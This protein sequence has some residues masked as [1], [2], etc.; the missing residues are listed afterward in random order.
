MKH[1]ITIDARMMHFTGIGTYVRN[2]LENFGA[3]EHEFQFKVLCSARDF[4]TSLLGTRFKF[5]EASSPI[6]SLR[7]QWEIMRLASG[8]SLLHCPHYNIPCLYRGPL[9]V[10]IHDLS[11][12][13]CRDS[14]PNRFAYVYAKIMF[15]TAVRHARRVITVSN[16]SR[17]SIQQR[18]RLPR[19]KIRVIYNRLSDRG[20]DATLAPDL[21]R[22]AAMK[23][24][25]PYILFV[26]MLKPY[27]NVQGLIRAFAAISLERRNS[28]QLVVVGKKSK[29]YPGLE[30]LTKEIGL[31]SK[32][33]FTDYISDADLE[34]LYAGAA[35]FVLPSFNEGFGLTVLEAMAH[36]VPVIVSDTSS[37]PDVA[38]DAG[39]LV[40]PRDVQSIASAIERVIADE[41]LR[42]RLARRGQERARLFSAKECARQHLEVYRE[43][44]DA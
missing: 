24:S 7:E 36:G 41:N 6:Y 33:V 4:S 35:V 31:E 29:F 9:V 19:E 8:S 18:F 42:R 5:V 40:D 43:V 14:L 21:E 39:I 25:R 27:K 13:V 11:H 16:F 12:L 26:G 22:L 15:A 1:T 20:R 34:V 37:L 3:I 23:V 28:H 30:R 44:L 10:T 2:L 17:D 38:G 32:V